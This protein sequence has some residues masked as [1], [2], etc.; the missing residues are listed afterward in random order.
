MAHENEINFRRKLENSRTKVRFSF[1]TKCMCSTQVSICTF[2]Y[3]NV[4]IFFTNTLSDGDR[5]ILKFSENNNNGC[6]FSFAK[7][8]K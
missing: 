3:C 1:N 8:S 5:F 6:N 4:Y 2:L 7:I